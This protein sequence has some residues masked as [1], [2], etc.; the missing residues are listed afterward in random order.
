MQGIWKENLNGWNHKDSKRKKTTRKYLL[1]EKGR[2]IEKIYDGNYRYKSTKTDNSKYYEDKYEL[3]YTKDRYLKPIQKTADVLRVEF[4]YYKSDIP[5]EKR[6]YENRTYI[7]AN[8]YLDKSVNH[9]KW[10]MKDGSDI[11]DKFN[12]DKNERFTLTHYFT[13]YKVGKIDLDWKPEAEKRKEV[14]IEE[15]TPYKV[16]SFFYK[17]PVSSWQRMTWFNDGKR[18]KIAQKMVNGQQRTSIRDWIKKGDWDSEIPSV[19]G[20]KSISWLIN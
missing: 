10:V 5:R 3:S 13:Y 17:K 12:L 15:F 9:I 4:Y 6:N 20:A 1:K 18:R 14:E 11:G 2:I 8:V 16:K 19:D 7:K